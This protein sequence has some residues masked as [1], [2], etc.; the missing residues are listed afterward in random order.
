MTEALA[1][2]DTLFL[3]SATESPMRVEEHRS[4]VDAAVDAGIRR[5]VYTSFV[6]AAP[7]AVFTFA[8]HHHATEEYIRATGLAYTFL[9]DNPYLDHV[10]AFSSP[11]GVIAGPAGDGRAAWVSRDDVAAVAAAVLTEDGH[12][13]GTYEVTGRES[14]TLEYAAEVL[15]DY[16]GRDVTYVDEGVDEAY[17]SRADYG[18]PDWEVEGWV[19]SYEAVAEGDFDVVT[20][21]VPVLTGHDAQ[22]LREYLADNPDSYTHLL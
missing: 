19:T 10:P 5:I 13:G 22:T 17:E 9:R 12:D 2:A 21:V 16:A 20:D 7:D 18:A 3:V 14:C 8:R 6:G 4:A 15:S 1:G 11:D